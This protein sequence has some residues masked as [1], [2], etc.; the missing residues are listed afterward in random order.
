[1][2]PTPEIDTQISFRRI[3][4]KIILDIRTFKPHEIKETEEWSWRKLKNEKWHVQL[5]CNTNR[6]KKWKVTT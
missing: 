3:E 2:I 6:L 4:Q 5:D 1:M